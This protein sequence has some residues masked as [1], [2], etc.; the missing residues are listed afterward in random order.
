MEKIMQIQRRENVVS[1]WICKFEAHQELETYLEFKYDEEGDATS[2]FCED[3]SMQWY[4]DE[5]QESEFSAQVSVDMLARF[6]SYSLSFLH[7]FSE[8]LQNTDLRQ[9][10]SI[11]LLYDHEY[12][13]TRR[14]VT[15]NYQAVFLGTFPYDKNS[16]RAE[17]RQ[18]RGV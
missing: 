1:V 13:G 10:N 2:R 8:A 17:A 5:S 7:A 12:T 11:I 16:P 9:A 3:F 15:E 4:N 6:A 14:V 18:S